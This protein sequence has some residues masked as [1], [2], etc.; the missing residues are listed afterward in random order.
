MKAQQHEMEDAELTAEQEDV[1]E[2]SIAQIA[3][4]IHNE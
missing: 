1:L 4:R 2:E 3:R